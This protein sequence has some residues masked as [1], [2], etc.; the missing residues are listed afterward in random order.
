MPVGRRECGSQQGVTDGELIH[1]SCY[2]Q[3]MGIGGTG[4]WPLNC[5]L[6]W[7]APPVY[8]AR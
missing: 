7:K 4:R 6:V 8:S 1:V 5:L 3:V 2:Q